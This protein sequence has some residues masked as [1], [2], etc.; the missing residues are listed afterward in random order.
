MEDLVKDAAVVVAGEEVIV[1]GLDQLKVR[2]MENH[3]NVCVIFFFKHDFIDC[4]LYL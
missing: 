4:F 3:V 2:D 1:I